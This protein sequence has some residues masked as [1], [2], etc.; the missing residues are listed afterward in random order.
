MKLFVDLHLE[1]DPGSPQKHKQ[2]LDYRNQLIHKCSVTVNS[3]RQGKLSVD[4]GVD[5]S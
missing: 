2:N 5:L 4:I 1:K 3:V